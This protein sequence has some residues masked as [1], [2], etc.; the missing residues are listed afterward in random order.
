MRYFSGKGDR[1]ETSTLNGGRVSKNNVLIHFEG[2]ADELNS[3]LGLVKALIT[4]AGIRNFIER[5]QKALMIVM[6][7]AS[8]SSNTQYLL[9]KDEID[10]LENEIDRLSQD[11]T[12]VFQFVLPGKS[13]IEAQIHIARTAARK[14]ERMLVAVSEQPLGNKEI[15][16]NALIFMNRLSSYLF[17]LSQAFDW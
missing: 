5:I 15:C 13:I 3:Q 12:K 17:V 10:I 2:A 7:H 4:D 9:Q 1:G 14:A 16:P 6:S 8:D 11:L